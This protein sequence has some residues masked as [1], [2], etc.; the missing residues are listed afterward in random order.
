MSAIRKKDVPRKSLWYLPIT[1][2]LQRLYMSRKT[3]K[4]MTWH[5][6]CR[7][8]ADEVMHL[9]GSEAWKHF[10]ETYPTF[11]NKP[12]NVRLGLYT[13]GFNSFGCSATPYSCWPIF[14]T[15]YNF[16]PEL[17]MKS[18]HIFLAMIIVGPKSPGKNID[19]ILRP[20]IDELK[21]LWT[22][23]VETYDSFKQQ[24]FIMKAAL[25]W[26]INDFPGYGMLSG[27]STN[28]RKGWFAACK[29]RARAII[30]TSSLSDGE[31]VYYQDDDPS[32]PQLVQPSTILNDHVSLTSQ[33]GEQVVISEVMQL[34]YVADEECVGEDDDQEEE[35]DGM[36]TSEKEEQPTITQ[37]PLDDDQYTGDDATMEEDTEERNLEVEL[38][39]EF[40]VLDPE[41]DAQLEEELS[42]VVPKTRCG[43]DKGDDA[44]VDPSQRKV[45]SLNH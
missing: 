41:L 36:K 44:P 11:A 27:W 38:D 1:P 43:M 40:A 14:L 31:N 10:D 34:P 15:V 12:R 33:R 19:I 13:D 7:E 23:G 37:P 3:T 29:I 4:H 6:K 17:C 21:E 28:G 9:A 24:N 45:L 42:C 8:D 39:V 20:L 26:I 5:L 16:P 18:E 2:R 25:L 35:F 32:M 30:N 22:N